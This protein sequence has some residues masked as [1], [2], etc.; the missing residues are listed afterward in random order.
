MKCYWY[1]RT[2]LSARTVTAI[3]IMTAI[4]SSMTAP[5]THPIIAA[6]CDEDNPRI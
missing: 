2:Y 6:S 1:D 4:N 5:R 3:T